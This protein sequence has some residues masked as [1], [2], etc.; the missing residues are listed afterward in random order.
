[1][2]DWQRG[3]RGEGSPFDVLFLDIQMPGRGGFELIDQVG[4]ANMPITVFVTAHNTYAIQAFEVNALDY[5]TKSVEQVRIQNT[6]VRIRERIMCVL[7]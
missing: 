2:Q 7:H 1:M 6:L 4:A 5:L 3:D